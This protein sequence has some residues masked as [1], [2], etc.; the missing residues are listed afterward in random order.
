MTKLNLSQKWKIVLTS[1]NKSMLYTILI[2]KKIKNIYVSFARNTEK[3]FEKILCSWMIKT[4]NKLGIVGNFF[5]VM[6]GICKKTIANIIL[7][8]ERFS[9]LSLRSGIGLRCPL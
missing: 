1:E 9:A 5:S 7:N 6:K 8:C 2:L 4:S 3:T